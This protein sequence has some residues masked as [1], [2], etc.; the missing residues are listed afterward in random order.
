MKKNSL[1]TL[2]LGLSLVLGFSLSTVKASPPM[3]EIV[4]CYFAQV[5]GGGGYYRCGGG[6]T[7]EWIDNKSA[8]MSQVNRECLINP[9]EEVLGDVD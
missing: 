7:C 9:G 5:N 4:T 2:F 8:H 3:P 6:Q 1:S